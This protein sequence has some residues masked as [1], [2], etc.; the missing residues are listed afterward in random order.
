MKQPLYP[1]VVAYIIG[2]I[3][4]KIISFPIW[5]FLICFVIF[6]SAVIYFL[7]HSDRKDI[8]LFLIFGLIALF[9]L[10]RMNLVE[11]NQIRKREIINKLVGV[12]RLEI[13]GEIASDPIVIN[14][15]I[16]FE[17]SKNDIFF[18][19]TLLY[20]EDKINVIV[21]KSA[22]VA[23]K[24]QR[25]TYGDRIRIS[26]VLRL[27][28]EATT[29]GLFN[30]KDYLEQQDVYAIVVVKHS[31]SILDIVQESKP[32]ETILKMKHSIE[33]YFYGDM[34]DKDASLLLAMLFGQQM[35]LEKS[36]KDSYIRCG[37][38]HIFAV[39]GQQ[40]GIAVLIFFMTMRIL[41]VKQNITSG[42]TICFIILYAM[43]TGFNPS[44]MRASIV[45]ICYMISFMI[46]REINPYNVLSFSAF[47]L[48]LYDPR[49]LFN[50]GFQLS[51][52]AVLGMLLMTS[53]ISDAI[54]FKPYIIS[55]LLSA[56]IAAQ[57]FTLPLVIYYF[58]VL[59]LIG[60]FSNLVIV[61]ILFGIIYTAFFSLLFGFIIHPLGSIFNTFNAYLLYIIQASTDFFSSLPLAAINYPDL[62]FLAIFF[63]YFAIGFVLFTWN[64]EKWSKIQKR[65]R[66]VILALVLILILFINFWVTGS[67]GLSGE[68]K[69]T[70]L[71]V[72]QGDCTY[73][74][75]PDGENMIVDGGQGQVGNYVIEPFL[76]DK[77]VNSIDCMILTHPDPDHLSGLCDVIKNFNIAMCFS[78]GAIQIN[79]IY[80]DFLKY[81]KD[82]NI[83]FKIV[84]RWDEI[85]YFKGVKIFILHPD[86][87]NFYIYSSN[88]QSIVFKLIYKDF[89][90]LMCGDI[91]SEAE[92]NIIRE[93]FDLKSDVLK[94]AH[95]G[96][97]TSSTE[98]FLERV[99][100]KITIIEVGHKNQFGHP[101]TE[102]LERLEK[103]GAKIYRTD[104]NGTIY[105]TTNGR[106]IEVKTTK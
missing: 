26:E 81:I 27:P 103:V 57:I 48:L 96:S 91:E 21:K 45:G 36:Q 100:P 62:S 43:L 79:P 93:R 29:E 7:N 58:N 13:E 94:V 69:I 92:Y 71:D 75:F 14:D 97:S 99:K 38:M 15:S 73:F 74:E 25:P 50:P 41:Q 61:P 56:T 19:D 39:S 106:K 53:I 11:S 66:L 80:I 34:E 95:H 85:D 20:F 89:S 12:Q 23:F 17:I 76:K 70:F 44:V 5:Y 102:V 72:G 30:Y 59:S 87:E 55:S 88:S 54:R 90:I 42:L 35:R 18:K 52:V 32:F 40:I 65:A 63:Y 105:L 84:K 78:N 98:K 47:I 82:K 28:Q 37:I 46:R 68:L 10:F 4:G 60:Y 83:N 64:S 86:E 51:F 77:G 22:F 24:E 33:N 9:G 104:L 67:K 49:L 31:E 6:S 8:S 101:N 1:I 3:V 16:R 2:I